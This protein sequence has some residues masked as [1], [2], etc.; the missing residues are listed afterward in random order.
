MQHELRLRL[1]EE[2]NK[3]EILR[4]KLPSID[5]KKSTTNDI[6]GEQLNIILDELVKENARLEVCSKFNR[7]NSRINYRKC[8]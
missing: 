7:K 1:D 2:K 3:V 6:D 8:R 5:A 4:S